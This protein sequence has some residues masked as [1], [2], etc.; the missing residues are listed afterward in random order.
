MSRSVPPL[1]Y[2]GVQI[3]FH[4]WVESRQDLFVLFLTSEWEPTV[5]SKSVCRNADGAVHFEM[6]L[7]QALQIK[8]RNSSLPL[9]SLNKQVFEKSLAIKIMIQEV[10]ISQRSIVSQ[11]FFFKTLFIYLIGNYRENLLSA[12]LLSQW[13]QQPELGWSKARSRGSK[14]LGHFPLL[15][16]MH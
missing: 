14:D 2:T 7:S 6:G 15:S 10:C 8:G 1:C 5:T 3:P 11:H 13:P 4:D 16:Q 12:S 9:Y